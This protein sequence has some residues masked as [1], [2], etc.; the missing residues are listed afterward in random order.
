MPPHNQLFP[1]AA[2]RFA[3]LVVAW[4]GTFAA[5]DFYNEI[6]LLYDAI[7]PYCKEEDFPSMTAGPKCVAIRRNVPPASSIPS[8]CITHV[9]S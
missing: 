2:Y 9:D 7:E 4:F 3:R 5:V 8:S 1:N 6:V